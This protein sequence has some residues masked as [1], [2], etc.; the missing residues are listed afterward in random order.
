MYDIYWG[1]LKSEKKDVIV[2]EELALGA[3]SVSVV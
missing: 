3:A 2:R 1:C